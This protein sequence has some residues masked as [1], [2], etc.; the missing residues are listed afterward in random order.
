MLNFRLVLDLQKN[1]KIFH[2]LYIPYPVSY[3]TK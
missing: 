3:I 2:F 1:C